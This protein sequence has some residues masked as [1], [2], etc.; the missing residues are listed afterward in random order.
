LE[1]EFEA[2][3]KTIKKKHSVGW[4]PKFR[5]SFN[6]EI[7]QA[8]F[9]TIVVQT[10]EKLGWDVVYQ[11]SNG[12]EAKRKGEWD[13]WTEKITVTNSNGLVQVESVSLG[14][15]IWD[16]GRN[17]KRVK[18]F[19]YAFEQVAAQYD[20]GSLAELEKEITKSDN[21]DDYEIPSELPTQNR[22]RKPQLWQLIIGVTFF[23]LIIGFLVA[24][25]SVNV[26]YIIGI[27]EVGVAFLLGLSFK[28]LIKK[29]NYTNFIIIRYLLAV[30]IL[31]VYLSNQYFQYQIIRYIENLEAIGFL[32]YMK[33]R[34][35]YGL[36][37]KTLNTGWIGLFLS[38]IFQLVFTYMIGLL[39]VIA[40]LTNYTIERVP[41]EVVDF[42]Y[43][44]FV[45]EKSEGE[46]REELSNMGWT[47]RQNQDEVFEAIGALGDATEMRRN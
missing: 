10:F 31:L 47:N 9:S 24:F 39:R 36:T 40:G 20:E 16:L 43:Y 33:L 46:V 23:A 19:I 8:V 41:F 13:T 7:N 2:F 17:S 44:H 37:I 28:F 34:I 32:A 5:A 27:Y 45:K 3:E 11:D 42:A 22:I 26:T 21:W 30:S 12:A 15:E 6:T 25:L 29:S 18:L 35:S 1:Q 38:W 14:N 4:T